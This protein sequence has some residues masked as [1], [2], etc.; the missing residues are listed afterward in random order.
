[1]TNVSKYSRY[2]DQGSDSGS[3]SDRSA[4]SGSADS[5][6]THRRRS[7]LAPADRASRRRRSNGSGRPR[8]DSGRY[9]AS[10]R[11]RA[12]AAPTVGETS[13]TKVN[14]PVELQSAD[15]VSSE[16]E[17]DRVSRRDFNGLR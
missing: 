4:R 3:G 8:T 2:S 10:A 1:M 9:T 14:T 12:S 5:R 17:P 16:E 7:T 15:E 11:S 6:A 13:E